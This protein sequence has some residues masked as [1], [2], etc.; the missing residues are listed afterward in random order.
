MRVKKGKVIS[1]LLLTEI[2]SERI[3]VLNVQNKIPKWSVKNTWGCLRTL[4]MEIIFWGCVLSHKPKK[5]TLINEHRHI[6]GNIHMHIYIQ[7]PPTNAWD[8]RDTDS[9]PGLGRSPGE[10]NGNSLWYFY[11]ENPMDSEIW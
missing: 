11:L 3:K 7:N 6:D 8:I 2:K 5:K 9:I 1:T 4:L 10:G